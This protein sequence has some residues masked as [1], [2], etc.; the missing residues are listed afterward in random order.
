[1]TSP[2]RSIREAGSEEPIGLDEAYAVRTPEDNRLL[3]ARWADTY[4]NGFVAERRYVYPKS[5]AGVF[6]DGASSADGPVL[7]VGCGTGLVGVAMCELGGWMLDGLDMSEEMLA[8][9]AGKVD[10][11]GAPVYTRLMTGDL[12]G[13]LDIPDCSY[14]GILS[15]GTFTHGHVGHGAF[16]ELYRIAR[17]GAR[18]AI[19]VNAEHFQAEGFADRFDADTACG[20]ISDL[21][22][23]RVPIYETGGDAG[24]RALVAVFSKV[25]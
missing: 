5:V 19:G 16:D 3:Y 13:R 6:A 25:T 9:A 21:V 7:D 20:Q 2:D 11:A 15:S 10:A 14:G 8:R 12:T 22:M 17:P 18:F 23:R 1:M 4:E 24:D